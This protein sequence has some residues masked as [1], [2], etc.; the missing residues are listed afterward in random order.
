MFGRGCQPRNHSNHLEFD[1]F[2]MGLIQHPNKESLANSR[3]DSWAETLY[4]FSE[5]GSSTA[6]RASV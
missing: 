6:E 4:L 5:V 1:I 2:R 3:E